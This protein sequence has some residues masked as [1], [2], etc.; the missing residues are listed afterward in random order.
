[1]YANLSKEEPLL[2]ICLSTH[3]VGPKVQ[4]QGRVFH[5]TFGICNLSTNGFL[6]PVM[7]SA[8]WQLSLCSSL[9][10]IQ[11]SFQSVYIYIVHKTSRINFGSRVCLHIH[12]KDH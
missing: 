8:Q 7:L 10:N 5:P 1:M 4:E 11:K 2:I 3:L 9:I 6:Y 12:I